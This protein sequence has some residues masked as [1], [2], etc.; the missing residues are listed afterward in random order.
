MQSEGGNTRMGVRTWIEGWPAYRQRQGRPARPRRGGEEQ[1]QRTLTA[2]TATADKVVKSVCPYCAV[3]CGQNVYVEGREGR[4]DRGRPRLAGQPGPAVPQGLGQPAA[5]HRP[6]RRYK[7]LY[8]RPHGT[9]WEPLDLD[10][11]MDM[12]ADRVLAARRRAGSGRWTASGSGARWA[13]RTSAARRSTTRRTTSSR[14]CSPRSARS[15][16]RTRRGFD[17]PPPSPVWGLSFG[18]GGATT[19]QQDLQNSDCIVIE[20]SNMAECHPVGF[21]WVMEAKARGATLIHVDPRFTRTSARG[22]PLCA[23]ARRE[24]TSRSSAG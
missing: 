4:P 18:R 16:S 21:Q 24:P 17:T 23:A 12:I 2:R 14:S 15:R 11:A 1:R 3:G 9:E 22:R 13:S 5:H 7:V 20:G 6:A 10:T 8:R 19:F